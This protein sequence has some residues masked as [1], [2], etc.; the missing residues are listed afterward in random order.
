MAYTFWILSL[1]WIKEFVSGLPVVNIPNGVCETCEIENKHRESFPNKK[2]WKVRKL[3]DTIHSYLC[4]VEIPTH[5]SSMY[6]IM[7]IYDCSRKTWVYF[8]KQ[9]LESCDAFKMFKAFVEKY[10]GCRIK[11]LRTHRPIIPHL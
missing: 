10:R 11:M 9:K 6:F 8:L 1:F 2:S 7:F 5:G 4:S 3:L